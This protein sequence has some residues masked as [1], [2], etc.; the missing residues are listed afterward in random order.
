M[1][2]FAALRPGEMMTVLRAFKCSAGGG[3]E[4]ASGN[5]LSA[6]LFNSFSS[7]LVC[8]VL[9]N[10]LERKINNGGRLSKHQ[11][12]DLILGRLRIVNPVSLLRFFAESPPRPSLIGFR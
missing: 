6:F 2:V 9:K 10:T 5:Q 12:G 7:F 1:S 4:D 8:R 3:G 11:S